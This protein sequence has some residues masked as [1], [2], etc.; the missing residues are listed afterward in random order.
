MPPC[1]KHCICEHGIE[2]EN[3][4]IAFLVDSRITAALPV[5]QRLR[6]RSVGT[7]QSCSLGDV[8]SRSMGDLSIRVTVGDFGLIA[9]VSMV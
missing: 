1:T 7:I 4:V 6:V 2:G 5:A 3:I 9:P 8:G